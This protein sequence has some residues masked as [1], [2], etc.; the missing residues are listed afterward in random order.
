MTELRGVICHHTMLLATR[1]KR[2][3]PT[4]IPAN[5]DLPTL[6]AMEGEFT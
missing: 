1:H 5:K 4:L 2:T 3:Q 6:G